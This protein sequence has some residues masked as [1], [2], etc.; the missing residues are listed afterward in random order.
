MSEQK[1][2]DRCILVVED[3]YLIADDMRIA[4]NDAGAKVLGPA[5]TVAAAMALL[6]AQPDL[7]GALLDVNLK[8]T[9]V[10]E[11]ADALVARAIPFV[12][13]TGYDETAIPDRFSS[14][15]LM[16]KPLKTCNLISALGPLLPDR[17]VTFS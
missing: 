6:T 12:F 10:F 4:L 2:R 16:E 7:D 5:P 1:L 14:V 3:E 11:L 9:M 17:E 13:A 8:G 15:P